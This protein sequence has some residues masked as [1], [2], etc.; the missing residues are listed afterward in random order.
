METY[1]SSSYDFSPEKNTIVI[2]CDNNIS[3]C[4]LIESLQ[5]KV[6]FNEFIFFSSHT[7]KTKWSALCY[8]NQFYSFK[9]LLHVNNWLI[10]VYFHFSQGILG[11]TSE[12]R[13]YMKHIRLHYV[14]IKSFE[15]WKR[16]KTFHWDRFCPPSVSRSKIHT[17]AYFIAILIGTWSLNILP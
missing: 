8:Q 17:H 6:S 11:E 2:S 16:N 10:C 3:N 4:A 14:S 7:S 13:S 15:L 12:K 5:I 9:I 1:F